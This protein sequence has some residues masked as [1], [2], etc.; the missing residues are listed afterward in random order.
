MLNKEK[1]VK[2]NVDKEKCTKCSTC[3]KNCPG[4]YL[5]LE[6]NQITSAKDSFLGCIQCGRCMIVC[7]HNAIDVE[8]E[9]ISKKDI[10]ELRSTNINYEELHSFLLK[11]RSAR[12][13]KEEEVS[14]ESIEKI[15]KAAST[16]AMSIPPS[17]VKV[18]IINGKEK[19]Q[20]FADDLVNSFEKI[21]KMFKLIKLFKP[22]MK[23]EKYQIFDEFIIPLIKET[24]NQRK[25]GKDILFYNAPA[26]VLFYNTDITDK[27][28]SII[29]A[30]TA[31]IAAETLGLGTCFI[32]SVP[33][34]VNNNPKLKGKYGILKDENISMAFILGFPKE[35]FTKGINR[36]FK[37]VKFY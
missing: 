11:R 30:T 2:I 18:L 12:E 15:I 24:V 31:T 23:K 26:V 22:F 16:S 13:F 20:E 14:N 8:G 3:I 25:N 7:P 5:I 32:G 10:T 9:G 36:R 37:E 17:E 33:P 1:P 21:L 27:E 19:V 29:A 6:N 4:E 28:D 35:N 34:A